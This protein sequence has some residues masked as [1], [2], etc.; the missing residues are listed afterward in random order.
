MKYVVAGVLAVLAAA[1]ATLLASR[2]VEALVDLT[3]PVLSGTTLAAVAFGVAGLAVVGGVALLTVPSRRAAAAARRLA[4]DVTGPIPVAG[5]R[6]AGSSAV[7]EPDPLTEPLTIPAPR[8][9]A[10]VGA[11]PVPSAP[12][13]VVPGSSEPSPSSESTERSERSESPESSESSE[14]SE[15][16]VPGLPSAVVLPVDPDAAPPAGAGAHRG[17]APARSTRVTSTPRTD[18]PAWA[19]SVTPSRHTAAERVPS[20]SGRG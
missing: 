3:R 9:S 11:A 16:V 1:G 7:A 12:P 15:P 19:G 10:P 5:S 8:T 6:R 14:P 2:R 17:E 20:W 18:A 13:D 4:S